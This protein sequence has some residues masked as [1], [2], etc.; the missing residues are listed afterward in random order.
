MAV[1]LFRAWNKNSTDEFVEQFYYYEVYQNSKDAVHLGIYFDLKLE[2]HLYINGSRRHQHEIV[3]FLDTT[4]PKGIGIGNLYTK[5]LRKNK[6][7][8]QK[9]I[10]YET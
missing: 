5:T 2:K 3:D 4:E 10:F 1:Q 7:I 8:R 6:E 9:I